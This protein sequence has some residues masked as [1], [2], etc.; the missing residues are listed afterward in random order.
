MSKVYVVE[1]LWAEGCEDSTCYGSGV[2]AVYANKEDAIKRMRQMAENEE[3]PSGWKIE[4][5]ETSWTAFEEG[6][7]SENHICLYVEEKE[8]YA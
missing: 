2:I 1:E 4:A 3:V 6:Y 5:S 8:L 7:Y